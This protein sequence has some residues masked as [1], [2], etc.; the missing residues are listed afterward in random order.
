MLDSADALVSAAPRNARLVI[1]HD[2]PKAKTSLRRLGVSRQYAFVA[3]PTGTLGDRLAFLSAQE[4]A[5]GASACVIAATDSPFVLDPFVLHCLPASP[6][7][8]VLAPCLDGG[9]WAVGLARPAP[10]IF[11]V[12][13]STA[14]VLGET[15]RRGR[16]LGRPVRLLEPMLD[17][18]HPG[19]LERAEAT[20]LLARSP[21]TERAWAQLAGSR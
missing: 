4:L 11:D 20:G 14:D 10:A 17:I 5:Q 2:P 1:F 13:M 3:Q 21:R 12:E 19:D 9:Y 7:E 18:D 15:V 16:S 8:I 6:E